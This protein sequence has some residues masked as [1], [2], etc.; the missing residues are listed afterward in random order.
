M[1][2]PNIWSRIN[3]SSS[4][5]PLKIEEEGTLPDLFYKVS[6]TLIPKPG[7]GTTR[8]ENYR[9]VF[10]V[11]RGATTVNKVPTSRNQPYI[12][13]IMHHDQV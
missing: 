10:L 13:S 6:L 3:I 1:I 5:I 2:S 7:K 9:P 4:Q 12:N 8:K 11:N